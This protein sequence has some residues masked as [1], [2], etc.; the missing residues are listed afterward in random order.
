MAR[1]RTARACACG[2]DTAPSHAQAPQVKPKSAQTKSGYL[3]VGACDA[4][5]RT[6]VTRTGV[7]CYGGG[8]WHTWSG[9]DAPPY[10]AEAGR[11]DRDLTLAGRVVIST[12]EARLRCTRSI[13]D[14]RQGGLEHRLVDVARPILRVPSLAI[15]LNVAVPHRRRTVTPRSAR[16]TCPASRSTLRRSWCL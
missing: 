15:H 4:R 6:C 11:F 3:S 2:C 9:Y 13:R 1:T 14:C 10:I 8:L 12:A 16:S 5:Y 7:E